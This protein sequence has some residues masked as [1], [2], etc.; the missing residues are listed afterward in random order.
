MF[1][2]TFTVSE[3]I[4]YCIYIKRTKTMKNKISKQQRTF[5][6]THSRIK[7]YLH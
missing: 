2:F 1:L 3:I 6:E 5:K 7:R 4:L